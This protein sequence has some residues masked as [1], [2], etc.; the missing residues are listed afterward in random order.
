[1]EMEGEKRNL[2]SFQERGVHRRKRG[3]V[4]FRQKQR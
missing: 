4:I 2:D 3:F 1:M